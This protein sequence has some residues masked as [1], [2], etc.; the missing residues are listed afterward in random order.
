MPVGETTA[1]PEDPGLSPSIHTATQKFVIL[2]PRG[3]KASS[4]LI[5][6][7]MHVVRRQTSR[8]KYRYT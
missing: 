3:A 8:Q 6:H 1:L 7:Y 5:R 4:G 2:V